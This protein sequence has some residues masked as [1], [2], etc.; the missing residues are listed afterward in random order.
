MDEE[1]RSLIPNTDFKIVGG[2]GVCLFNTSVDCLDK[3]CDR[4]G[5]NPEVDKARKFK[6]RMKMKMLDKQKEGKMRVG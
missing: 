4:C 6:L 1:M 5:W 3:K 2:P